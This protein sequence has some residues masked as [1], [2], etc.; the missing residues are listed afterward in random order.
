MSQTFY[1]SIILRVEESTDYKETA[2]A[3]RAEF[4][5]IGTNNYVYQLEK[6]E[7]G[8][9]HWQCFVHV[10]DK[11]RDRTLWKRLSKDMPHKHSTKQPWGVKPCSDAGKEALRTYCMKSDH[12]KVW[13]PVGK[14]KLYTGADLVCMEQPW[15]WQSEILSLIRQEPDNRSV[16][17]IYNESGNVGK[18][19]LM[20]YCKFNN[21]ACRIPLGNAQQIKTS[22]IQKGVHTCYMLDMPRVRGK[23]EKIAELFSAIEEIKNGWVESCMYGKNQ[24]LMMMSPHVIVFSNQIPDLRLAS[25]DR[26]QVYEVEHKQNPLRRMS[27]SELFELN[28][29]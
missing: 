27:N 4:E 16:L 23:D 9:Y 21:L 8:N 20:K 25:A 3:L 10:K 22:V 13:G 12:T 15:R 11:V 2:D 18:S 1:F 29:N 19:I 17:W 24:E 7:S 14:K 26:W 5:R 6:G 28:Q